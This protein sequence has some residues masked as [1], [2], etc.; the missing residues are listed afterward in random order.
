MSGLF[1]CTVSS[2]D[3][4]KATA[5]VVIPEREDMIK[6]GVPIM[7]T[8]YHMPSPGETVIAIFDDVNG[9]IQRGVIIGRPYQQIKTMEISA[10]TVRVKR[11][12]AD[13]ILYHNSCLKG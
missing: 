2:V 10:Q 13:D 5:D 12:E 7:D 3:Y 8:V 1:F 11:L 6:T 9:C 4:G